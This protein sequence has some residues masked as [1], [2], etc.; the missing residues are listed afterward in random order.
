[1]EAA[2]RY[3]EARERCPAG[4]ELWAKAT[5]AA[6]EKLK[7]PE[8]AEV[9]KPEWW[10]DKELKALSARVVKATPDEAMANEMRAA[11]LS[12][13]SGDCWEGGPRS[14]VELKKAATHYA[15]AAALHPAPLA[16][17]NLADK[18][19]RCRRWA[20]AM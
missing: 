6:F 3:L 11:M 14:A 16:K 17:A 12:G 9:A 5:A 1:M 10:N 19:A 4:S 13:F 2:Q 15:R 7:L 18:A 20:E 8:C